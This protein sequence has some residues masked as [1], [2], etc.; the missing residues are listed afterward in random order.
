M[1]DEHPEPVGHQRQRRRDAQQQRSRAQVVPV[2]FTLQRGD[3]QRNDQEM[4]AA[5]PAR[6]LERTRGYVD[7]ILF[8][9]HRNT[10]QLGEPEID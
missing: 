4:Q 8:H 5:A 6:D 3:R 7:E 10:Y 2:D 9:R 1:I